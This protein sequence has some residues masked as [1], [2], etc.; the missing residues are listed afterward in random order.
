MLRKRIP[1]QIKLNNQPQH[2]LWTRT[3]IFHTLSL[4][5]WN[6]FLQ[7]MAPKK[8]S[9]SSLIA[10]FVPAM[11]AVLPTETGLGRSWSQ[12]SR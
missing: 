11:P 7:S 6:T 8:S 5:K 9:K 4:P 2:H 12:S 10:N 1:I 3:L